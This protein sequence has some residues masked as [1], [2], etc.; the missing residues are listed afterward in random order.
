[1][2]KK[3]QWQI[4]EGHSMTFTFNT[5]KEG[6]KHSTVALGELAH[7]GENKKGTTVRLTAE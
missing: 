2:E 6:L 7:R 1:M 4:H 3:N 5:L